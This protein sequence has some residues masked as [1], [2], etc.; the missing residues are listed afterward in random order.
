M[1]IKNFKKVDSGCL[2]A[3]FTVLI[4][5]WGQME[6]DCKYFEKGDGYWIN[7]APKE[8][9]NQEG[10]KKSWNQTRWPQNVVDKLNKAIKEKLAMYWMESAPQVDELGKESDV[11]F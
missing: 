6:V 4:P 5:E 9:T 8:Y 7:Y 10:K 2:K 1:E 11:P 3:T